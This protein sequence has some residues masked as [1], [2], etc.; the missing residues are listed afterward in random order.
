MNFFE[1]FTSPGCTHRC[2]HHQASTSLLKIARTS[3]LDGY[4]AA[5]PPTTT[6]RGLLVNK[7]SFLRSAHLAINMN[8]LE[9]IEERPVPV[10]DAKYLVLA[11]T[12]VEIPESCCFQSLSS[13]PEGE[14]NSGGWMA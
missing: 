3:P 5:D 9:E 4:A 13:V 14:E 7:C 6:L 1:Y 2:K 12:V 10:L 11:D 8:V